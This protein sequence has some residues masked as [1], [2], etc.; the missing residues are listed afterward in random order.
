MGIVGDFLEKMKQRKNR[1]DEIESEERMQNIA[2]QKKLS[3][4]ERELIKILEKDKQQA[5]REA[6]ILEEKK[7][8][9]EEKLKSRQMMQSDFCLFRNPSIL[10]EKQNLLRGKWF[11]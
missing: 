8:R 5:I 1:L 3:H 2:N 9:A 6:L 11:Y 4:N 10:K 7:R